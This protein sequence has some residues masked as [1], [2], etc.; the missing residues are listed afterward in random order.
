[1]EWECEELN[2]QQ[3]PHFVSNEMSSDKV[4]KA[5]VSLFLHFLFDCLIVCVL[6]RV[7]DYENN[8]FIAKED[9]VRDSIDVGK[10]LNE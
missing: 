10:K 3:G 6:L 5:K 1:M 8:I 2:E 9:F 4:K 7:F